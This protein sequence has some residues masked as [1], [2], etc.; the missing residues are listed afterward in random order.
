M[1]RYRAI[2]HKYDIHGMQLVDAPLVE[3]L[4]DGQHAQQVPQK[5][6]PPPQPCSQPKLGIACQPR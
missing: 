6:L 3:F 2:R 1:V 5:Q 4:H